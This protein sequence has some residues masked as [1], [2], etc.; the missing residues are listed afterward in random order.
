MKLAREV[1]EEKFEHRPYVNGRIIT[2]SAGL[3][4]DKRVEKLDLSA[5][6][7]KLSG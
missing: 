2:L 3:R 6:A 1:V 4:K 5:T 7:Q